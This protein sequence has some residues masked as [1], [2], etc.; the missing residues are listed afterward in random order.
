MGATPLDQ[1]GSCYSGAFTNPI[2][3]TQAPHYASSY[4]ISTPSPGVFFAPPSFPRQQH[5]YICHL[6]QFNI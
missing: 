5:K 2:F 1:Y 3:F 4:H 6:R